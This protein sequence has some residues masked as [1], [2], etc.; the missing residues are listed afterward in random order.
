MQRECVKAVE[1]TL[2]V[3]KMEIQF[4]CVRGESGEKREFQKEDLAS[5]VS[6]CP[7]AQSKASAFPLWYAHH[8]K[9]SLFQVPHILGG[10]NVSGNVEFAVVCAP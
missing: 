1:A 3:W 10:A 7:G 8:C 9:S 6:V 2:G 4:F 5:F